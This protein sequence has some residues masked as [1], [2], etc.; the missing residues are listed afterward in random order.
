MSPIPV[1]KPK[2]PSMEFLSPYLRSIDSSRHY[3]NFGPLV[4]QLE[5]RLCARYGMMGGTIATVT[6]GTLGLALALGAQNVSPGS[7][8]MLPAWTFVASAHAAVM[9]GLVPYFVDVDPKTWMLDTSVVCDEIAKAPGRIGAV[10][11]VAPFGRPIDIARWDRFRSRNDIPVVVDAAAGFDSIRAGETPAVVSLH[12]TKVIGVGE[13]GF[14]MSTDKALVRAIRARSNFGFLGARQAILPSINAKLSEYHAAVGLAALDEWECVRGQWLSVAQLYR[15]ALADMNRICF[16][17][18]FGETWIASTCVLQVADTN[19]D[20]VERKL[21]AADIGTRRWW[22]HGAHAHPATC[23]F[24]RTSLPNT[25]ALS[26]ST[27]GVP[28]YVDMNSTEIEHVAK[29]LYAA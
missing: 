2:L 5:E 10:M 13:G 15:R 8:C 25:E 7:F 29:A 18:G 24:P 1:M 9:A 17:D 28:L 14:V 4:T 12:A 26:G 19:A 16:Q 20:N 23:S 22:G 6:N 21:A 27:I 11:P 3:S